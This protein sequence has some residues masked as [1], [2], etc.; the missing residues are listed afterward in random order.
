[1]IERQAT[2]SEAG[3]WIGRLARLG[4]VCAGLLYIVVG[5]LAIELALGAGGKTTDRTGALHEIAQE[6][7]GGVLL[8]ILAIGFAGYALWRFTAAALG[9]KVETNDDFGWGKRLWYVAR[10]I[11]YAFLCYTTVAILVGSSSGSQNEKQ[12]T[13]AVLDWPGGRWIVSAIGLGVLGYGLGSLYRGVTGKFKDDLRL[14]EMSPTTQ[15]W[16]TRLGFVGYVARAVVFG[17]VGIFIVR[18]ALE[19]DPDEAVG[20]DGA[21][22]KLADQTFGPLLL[23]IVAAG[24]VAFGLFYFV[25]AR[26]RKV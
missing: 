11:F 23:G 7:W 5:F 6:S 1:M 10:G 24:L 19:Y 8:V 14:E 16:V 21:L 9:E 26:Y 13:E 22:Q 15:R 2:A 4:M 12:Q 25:R 18:A 3:P 20:V 17:L